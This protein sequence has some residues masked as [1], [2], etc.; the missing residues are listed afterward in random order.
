MTSP[1]RPSRR[2][3]AGA[4]VASIALAGLVV[5]AAACASSNPT[6]SPSSATAGVVASGSPSVA[7]SP[8]ASPAASAS[9]APT[10]TPEPTST[11]AP[12]ATQAPTATPAPNPT[13]TPAPTPSPWAK[14]TSTRFKYAIDY[15][16]GWIVTKGDRTHADQF[17]NY[18]YPYIYVSRDTVP[19]TISVSRTVDE[20]IRQTRSHFKAKVTTNKGIK[21]AGGYSGRIVT[22]TGVDSGV[23]VTIQKIIVGKGNAAYF[24]SM[25]AETA[26]RDEGMAIFQHMYRSWRP[27]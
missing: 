14:H 11:A 27:R 16:T 8:V 6:P 23:A 25:Y 10:S 19:G 7:A 17:D 21:L 12:T 22:F 18:A 24:L 2:R 26:H 20:V 1:S 13:P 3:R 9:V 15:P 4:V 5:V